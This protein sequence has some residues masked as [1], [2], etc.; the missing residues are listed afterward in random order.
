MIYVLLR[1]DYDEV[2]DCT[3]VEGPAGIDVFKLG[4][5]FKN[6]FTYVKLGRPEYPSTEG[7]PGFPYVPTGISSGSIVPGQIYLQQDSPQYLE[8]NAA[9]IRI[10][11]EWRDRRETKIVEWKKKYPGDDLDSMFL[12]LLINDH[13]FKVLESTQVWV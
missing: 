2:E 12:S 7:I 5:E 8:W 13:G 11:A 1:R 6:E 4:K 9:R 10:D 3:V